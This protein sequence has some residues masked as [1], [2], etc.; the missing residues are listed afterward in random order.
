MMGRACG[1]GIN[2][3]RDSKTLERVFDEVVVAVD[4]VLHSAA[5]FFCPNGH[6]HAMLIAA[7]YEEHIL[8]LRA[9]ISHIDVGWHIH[10]SEVADMDWA[11][12]IGKGGCDESS[13][14][15]FVHNR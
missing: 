1:S 8:A 11:I 7:A 14:I 6:R 3:K 5:F 13:F 9:E 15:I 4:H 2:I 10:A 12:G